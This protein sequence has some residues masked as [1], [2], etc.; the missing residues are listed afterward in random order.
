MEI[1]ETT[2]KLDIENG[3]RRAKKFEENEERMM[4]IVYFSWPH[5]LTKCIQATASHF[6]SFL[7]SLHSKLYFSLFTIP[8]G[9][10]F[11]CCSLRTRLRCNIFVLPTFIF[12]GSVWASIRKTEQMHHSGTIFWRVLS[13]LKVRTINIISCS[14]SLIT[15]EWKKWML[16]WTTFSSLL[17]SIIEITYECITSS[18]F[19]LPLVFSFLHC[20]LLSSIHFICFHAQIDI[21][22]TNLY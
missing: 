14:S 9:F 2:N 1:R 11:F 19:L 17:L 20:S 6:L 15:F 5:W 3:R 22:K 12:S 8:N 16:E 10:S 4:M 7:L 13:C 21:K 18:P